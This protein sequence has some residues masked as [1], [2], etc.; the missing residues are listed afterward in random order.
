MAEYPP[1]DEAEKDPG[2]FLRAIASRRELHD[3]R[4]ASSADASARVSGFAGAPRAALP[5]ALHGGQLF[6]QAF[7]HPAAPYRRL[8]L[9]WQTGSGKTLAIVAVAQEYV[10]RFRTLGAPGRPSPAVYVVAAP[11]VRAL[12]VHELLSRPELGYI[13]RAEHLE[14]TR[15]RAAAIAAPG[16]AAR[17]THLSALL[18]ALKQRVTNRARGGLFRFLG[19]QELANALF[20]LTKRG[21]KAGVTVDT[22]LS[23]AKARRAGEAAGEAAETEATLVGRIRAAVEAGHVSVDEQIMADL[24]GGV[25]VVDEAQNAYNMQRENNY[26]AVIGYL[27]RAFPPD[28]APRALFLSATPMTG[29]A[30]EIVDLVGL[31]R[32]ES[33]RRSD[34]FS[35]DGT[36]QP[37]AADRLGRL[38]AGRVSALLDPGIE[39]Y[40]RV[41]EDGKTIPDV[42][43]LHFIE[44][45]PSTLQRAAFAAAARETDA[46]LPADASGLVDAAFPVA[47]A[48][49]AASAAPTGTAALDLGGAVRGDPAAAYRSAP[50]AWLK[51]QG[52]EVV[53][54]PTPS[55]PIV[56]GGPALQAEKRLGEISPKYAALVRDL[57]KW[58]RSDRSGKAL[59]YHDRVRGT[60]VLFVAE[61]LKANGFVPLGGTPSRRTICARCGEAKGAGKHAGHDYA[62]ARYALAHYHVEK[63][64]MQ[65]GIDRF[66]APTNDD[67]ADV[68]ILLGARI[69]GVGRTFRAVRRLAI[70]SLPTDIPNLI[71]VRGRVIR[72]GTHA[73]LPPEDRTVTIGLYITA[74]SPEV[75]RYIEKGK[76]FLEI[77]EVERALRAVAVDARSQRD[78][79]TTTP[80][81]MIDGTTCPTPSLAGLP[82]TPAAGSGDLRPVRT[83]YDAL[84]YASRDA[85]LTATA[86]TEL[87]RARPV[88]TFGDLVDA[89]AGVE[90]LSVIPDADTV[91]LAIED[92]I[93][94]KAVIAAPPYFVRADVA[95]VGAYLRVENLARTDKLTVRLDAS[96]SSGP[97]GRQAVKRW[98]ESNKTKLADPVKARRL[99]VETSENELEGIVRA[100][101]ERE[102]PAGLADPLT[103]LL[104]EF[105]I[106]VYSTSAGYTTKPTSSPPVGYLTSN[107]AHIRRGQWIRTLRREVA[108]LH[109]AQMSDGRPPPPENDV[110]IGFS[111]TRRGVTAF[112]I[113]Q[114]LQNLRG[115]TDARVVSRGGVCTTRPR[116]VIESALRKTSRTLGSDA[117]ALGKGAFA[118]AI[119]TA[120][121]DNLLE[122]EV[123]ERQRARP[124]NRWIYLP[125]DRRPTLA[126]LAGR[127]EG[128]RESP[129]VSFEAW[130][131]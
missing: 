47:P 131:V 28:E 101:I 84:G 116:S 128:G 77:Q 6:V 70:L 15:L 127:V 59:V 102:I 63:G 86:V 34:F 49:K 42:P 114:P 72:R 115:S 65:R 90:R 29:S 120:L 67:G 11:G 17:Q 74:P 71:Q 9:F 68:K 33:L 19:Y 56:V 107:A 13:S 82:Y 10:R 5:F 95:N 27:L 103:D 112:R 39:E 24:R 123:R 98:I 117:P 30:A 126:E 118:P 73:A 69:I 40:P 91:A 78:A 66:N 130:G 97:T 96:T 80:R 43:Y 109:S 41:V 12:V 62:P 100:L 54:G 125:N 60:G 58:A 48:D 52:L 87:F 83:T 64:A 88:W 124:R 121:L 61:V 32:G 111:E 16:D 7:L 14:V 46:I 50:R 36:L 93:E 110:I 21:K 122:L 51:S 85:A 113:R 22:L 57:H 119:C 108:E 2:A 31:L 4:W 8:L 37:G 81:L 105:K 79:A 26:G 89:M 129:P 1:P 38:A 106:L 99:L 35:R 23:F 18:G 75:R 55:A 3:L 20:R 44:S 92:A 53:F 45:A 25:L 76:A 104:R 94:L